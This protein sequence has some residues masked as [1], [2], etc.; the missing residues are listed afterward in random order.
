MVENENGAAVSVFPNPT[1]SNM[2][3]AVT[4]P[5]AGNVVVRVYD[6]FGKLVQTIFD[7]AATAGTLSASWN[8][9]DVTGASVAAGT[10]V[11]RVDGAGVNTS[12]MVTVVR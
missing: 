7:G 4:L 3:M 10:Y 5:E 1:S 9:T 8:G 12:N 11:V 6:A 2:S